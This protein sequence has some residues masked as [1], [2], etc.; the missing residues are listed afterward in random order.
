M[1]EEESSGNP[2]EE[3]DEDTTRSPS[4]VANATNT[5]SLFSTFPIGDGVASELMRV[6]ES[7]TGGAI[8]QNHQP[9]IP[10]PIKSASSIPIP[11][12]WP[13]QEGGDTSKRALRKRKA[14]SSMVVDEDYVDEE[15]A[16]AD[17]TKMSRRSKNKKDLNGRWSKRFTWPDELHR[18]FVAAIFDVGLKH[19][20]PSS[21]WLNSRL[22]TCA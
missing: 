15:E 13:V 5:S 12:A 6:Y 7:M 3:Q 14:S 9:I 1:T 4:D 17:E 19:S 11:P 20:S 2:P 8:Q 10:A 18:D 21:K 16:D 22:K